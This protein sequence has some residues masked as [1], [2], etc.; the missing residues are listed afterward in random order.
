MIRA[1]ASCGA[2]PWTAFRRVTVPSI[3]PSLASGALFAFAAS[4]DD[5]VVALFATGPNQR[6]LP[7]EMYSSLRETISPELIAVATIMM[8]FST[9]LFLLMQNLQ[10]RRR[11]MLQSAARS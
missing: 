9:A 7:R 1:A 4:F 10:R 6:K 8:I 2:R 11:R 5:V 3:A